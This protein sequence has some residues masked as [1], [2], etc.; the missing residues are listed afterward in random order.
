MY[1][2][3]VH[4]SSLNPS[5]HETKYKSRYNSSGKISTHPSLQQTVCLDKKPNTLVL[6]N[7]MDERDLKTS[8]EHW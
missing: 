8:I 7:A 6:N 4:P 5:E 1:Q 3:L 2:M